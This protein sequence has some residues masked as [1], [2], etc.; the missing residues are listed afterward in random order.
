MDGA[1]DWECST[2]LSVVD[3]DIRSQGLA[4]L[5]RVLGIAKSHEIER[6]DRAMRGEAP[7]GVPIEQDLAD[8]KAVFHPAS[9]AELATFTTDAPEVGPSPSTQHACATKKNS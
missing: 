2:T 9:A 3:V 1:P 7:F 4:T 6:Y 5:A 8:T